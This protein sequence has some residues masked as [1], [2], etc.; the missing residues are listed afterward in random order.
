MTLKI[1][2][3]DVANSTVFELRGRIKAEHIKE[4]QALLDSGKAA[5]Q[6]VIDL[7]EVRIVDRE[8]V[9]FLAKCEAAGITLRDCPDYIREW[10]AGIATN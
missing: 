2:R 7:K 5:L 3:Y 4:L 6:I 9:A 1:Q 10:I 8:A